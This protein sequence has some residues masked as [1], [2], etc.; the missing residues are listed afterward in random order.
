MTIPITKPLFGE[1]GAAR[2]S[3]TARERVGGSRA[4]RGRVRASR[5]RVHEVAA[6]RRDE[7]LHHCSPH[8]ARR[9]RREAGRRGDRSRL[10][11]GLDGERRRV[12][13]SPPGLLRRRSRYL[14]RSAVGG[15]GGR[16]GADGG[17]R[18][19]PPLR[20]SCRSRPDHRG[21]PR[22]LA[23]GGRGRRLLARE[24]G[25]AGVIPGRSGTPGA[26]A[27][28]RASRSRRAKAGC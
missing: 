10:H 14:Q 2:G 27:S 5:R 3:A 8:R 18:P 22:T 7:L 28:I 9:A 12:P 4:T 25:T 21:R 13:G 19:R 11:V 1:E 20:A 26:S 24:A 16:D 15:R 23:V 17:N 6:C